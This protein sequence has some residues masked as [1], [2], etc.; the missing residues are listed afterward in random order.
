[1]DAANKQFLD[2]Y[3]KP[4]EDSDWYYRVFRISDKNKSWVAND[5][6][7]SGLQSVNTR[8]F[9]DAFIHEKNTEIWTWK[10][11]YVQI[12]RSH[13]NRKRKIPAFDLAVWLFRKRDWPARTTAEDIVRA[14]IE[15]FSI[16][17]YEK[18]LLFD[19]SVRNSFP[20]GKLFQERPVS[21]HELRVLTGSPP[22][23]RQEKR[24][25]TYLNIVLENLRSFSGKHDIPIKP[26]T[27]LIGENSSGKTT[28][29][30]ALSA[31]CKPAFPV[32]PGF[33]DA[34]YSLGSFDTIATNAKSGT[35][36]NFFRIGY[37]V[38][39]RSKE[40]SVDVTARYRNNRGQVELSDFELRS[41]IGEFRLSLEETKSGRYRAQVT[42]ARAKRPL[43]A[44]IKRLSDT[45]RT[46]LVRFVTSNIIEATSNTRSKTRRRA[47]FDFIDQ[48]VPISH[49]VNPSRSL[50]VAP[51]RSKPTRTYDE[52]S[53][54][55]NP[56]G[57]H[58]PYVLSRILGDDSSSKQKLV[59][60]EALDRFGKESGLFDMVD[61]KPLANDANLPFQIVVSVA[62]LF[63]L[64]DVGY[65]V[66]QALPIIVQSVL[67]DAP[68]LLL[69]QQPEVHLH[70]VAQA[71]L[72]SF[73]ARL[74][75]EGNRQF[76]IETHSDF[77]VDRIRQEV[78]SG[79][80]SPDAVGIVFLDKVGIETK[81]YPLELDNLGN[82]LGAPPRYREFFLQEE[83]NLIS[84][85]DGRK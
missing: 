85:D 58:I 51:I 65:G 76:V 21:W 5:Y 56:E 41:F 64:L 23:A 4:D 8:T 68:P 52:Q 31:V 24:K 15:E 75:S 59:L 17:D 54:E 7:S 18:T 20:P 42:P 67:L 49:Y 53:D 79:L 57:T 48:L 78:A 10:E 9:A 22:D 84:G 83:L 6:A 50:S 80:I 29:L 35:K 69:V 28:L 61:V 12:L 32:W 63:N 11:D 2:Q 37:R 43:T 55:F 66:S 77:I 72:G 30:A 34:P 1:M 81:A 73:F 16:T 13:L 74:V 33:N 14:F 70:P 60:V 26:L 44:F 3:Y 36:A 25:I 71:A 46:D 45:M 40:D 47:E 62:G 19:T 39:G 82:V 27:I 38:R